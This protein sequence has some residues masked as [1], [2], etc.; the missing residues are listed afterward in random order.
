MHTAPSVVIVDD[1]SSNRTLL[2]RMVQHTFPGQPV[3]ACQTGIEACAAIARMPVACVLTDFYLGANDNGVTL[4]ATLHTY[5]PDLPI[6]LITGQ[7]LSAAIL[8][9][10]NFV[11]VLPK[12]IP[13][14]SLCIL[15]Q[16]LLQIDSLLD[17]T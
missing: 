14:H 1:Q 17:I 6:I 12:P 4:A 3:V 5:W 11:A 16:P 13:F 9:Q 15:L 7:T 8:D 10:G 2:V